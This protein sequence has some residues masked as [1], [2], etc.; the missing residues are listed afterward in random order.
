MKSLVR[1]S[2]LGTAFLALSYLSPPVHATPLTPTGWPCA[3]QGA[4]TSIIPS[5]PGYVA[6][7]GAWSGNNIGNAGTVANVASEIQSDFGLTVGPSVDITGTNGNSTSGT[8]LLPSDQTGLFVI[9]LK[10]GDAFSLYEFNGALVTG[11]ISS[12]AFDDFGIGFNSPGAGGNCNVGGVKWMCDPAL[13]HADFYSITSVP[14]PEP[15][16]LALFGLGLAGLM[17]G[18][19]RKVL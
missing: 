9:A 2:A 12:I 10:G 16:T 7:S 17:L 19:R 3:G 1:R 4:F 15:G 8:L 13:S 6:C 18:V 5:D 14:T 11:G